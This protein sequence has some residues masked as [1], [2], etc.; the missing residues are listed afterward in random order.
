LSHALLTS[1]TLSLRLRGKL[2]LWV[3]LLR[4]AMGN[5]LTVR[6]P[7][8]LQEL[9]QLARVICKGPHLRS[10][11]ATRKKISI[12]MLVSSNS[13]SSNNSSRGLHRRH[14]AK[15]S[16]RRTRGQLPHTHRRCAVVLLLSVSQRFLMTGSAK[17]RH[18]RP[19]LGVTHVTLPHATRMQALA[20]IAALLTVL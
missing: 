7:T 16:R 2:A 19:T 1:R 10:Q 15:S 9:E 20:L 14:R 5:L 13:S 3:F 8:L 4:K 6:L 12:P 18:R 17:S 11:R